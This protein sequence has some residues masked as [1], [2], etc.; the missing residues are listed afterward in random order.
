MSDC[1]VRCCWL[2]CL[3]PLLHNVCTI[4][5]FSGSFLPGSAFLFL[6][7]SFF[8][9]FSLLSLQFT[10]I[11]VC[12]ASLILLLSSSAQLLEFYFSEKH[13][14]RLMKVRDNCKHIL[15][16]N[17]FL[18]KNK[19]YSLN[20][21]LLYNFT[22]VRIIFILCSFLFYAELS[23]FLVKEWKCKMIYKT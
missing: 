8:F 12:F 13:L 20:N 14:T 22:V 19:V 9:S 6:L 10:S 4:C 2:S 21:A 15:W 16:D 23:L 17:V 3:Y 1:Y 7:F 11:F 18:E 5:F